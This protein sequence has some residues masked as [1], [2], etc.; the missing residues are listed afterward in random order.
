MNKH[1]NGEDERVPLAFASDG[2][3]L[4]EE[5][6]MDDEGFAEAAVD[7]WKRGVEKWLAENTGTFPSSESREQFRAAALKGAE[8]LAITFCEGP[9]VRRQLAKL[10]GRAES[11]A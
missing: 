5:D 9:E 11:G 7:R 4:Y 6:V 8:L 2:W 1:G 3:A 10:A